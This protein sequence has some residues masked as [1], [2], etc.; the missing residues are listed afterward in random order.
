MV[1]KDRC[2]ASYNFCLHINVIIV[3]NELFTVYT[4]TDMLM[5]RSNSGMHHRVREVEKFNE[6]DFLENS[7]TVN[8]V[9]VRMYV[10]MYIYMN[11]YVNICGSIF[12][13][14]YPYTYTCT[15]K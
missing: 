10:Y 8:S 1:D 7:F 11:I 6:S 5:A 14:A 4:I 9:Y 12:I 3:L 13:N 2:Y 15:C